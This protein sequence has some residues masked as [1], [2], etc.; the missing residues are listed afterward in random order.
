MALRTH[1]AS[2]FT[3]IQVFQTGVLH[4]ILESEFHPVLCLCLSPLSKSRPIPLNL[5]TVANVG[6]GKV[7][8]GIRGALARETGDLCRRFCFQKC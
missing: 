1:Y 2:P 8:E 7:K 4:L 5:R 3:P 6:F